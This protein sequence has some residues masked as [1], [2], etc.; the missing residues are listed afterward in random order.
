[1]WL[2]TKNYSQGL[3]YEPRF[4]GQ[5][6]NTMLESLLAVPL[7]KMGLP[8]Y[9]ALPTVTTI[10]SLF[11][12]LMLAI[13]TYRNTSKITGIVILSIFIV[14]PAEYDFLTSISRGFVTGIAIA[15]ICFVFLA[16]PNSKNI[17]LVIGF[18]CIMAYSINAN[19]LLLSIPCLFLLFLHNFRN[20]YFYFFSGSGLLV[21]LIIHLLI[22]KF[23]INNPY[24]IL[25]HNYIK[26]SFDYFA[27]SISH[28]DKFFNYLVPFFWNHGWIILLIFIS[29]SFLLFKKK[30]YNESIVVLSIPFM[31]LMTLF[32]SKVNDGTN[33]IF[34]SFA[35][36]YL[37]I[38]V[39]LAFTISL[40]NLKER[41][42]I[43]A[44]VPIAIIFFIFK[45]L[46]MEQSIDKNLNKNHV[47]SVIETKKLYKECEEISDISLNNNIELIII[48]QH[49]HYDFYNYGCPSC[50]KRFPKTLRPLYERRTWRLIEDEHMIYSNILIIDLERN[51]EMEYGFISKIEEKNGF[52]VIKG[53]NLPTMTLLKKLNIAVRKYK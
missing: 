25:H 41:K 47:I 40:F 46:A 3:F 21:G 52:Y 6:Y 53:N 33:S 31:V 10:L 30:K 4:Y 27:E 38:P 8:L 2:A 44:F 45:V 20:K 28:L 1:M 32:I 24:Y 18:L 13:I 51:L 19:S 12:F 23:Y 14:F 7:F 43:Y 34:F 36:M 9:I 42:W 17:F 35:R 22:A 26:F 49:W 5:S 48:C 11:P 39:L 37:A 50:M 16:K 29:A 15:S